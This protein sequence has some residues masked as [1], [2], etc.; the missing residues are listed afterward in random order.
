MIEYTIYC[1]C[2]K[3]NVYIV[4]LKLYYICMY[5]MLNIYIYIYYIYID[6]LYYNIYRICF[7]RL[8]ISYIFQLTIHSVL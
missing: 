4:D 8:Y 5:I 6:F 7:N 3:H 2:K 1:I